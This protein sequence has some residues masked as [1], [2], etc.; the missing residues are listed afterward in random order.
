MSKAE[1]T[2][3]NDRTDVVRAD[4]LHK[5]DVFRCISGKTWQ[6]VR[7]TSS[8]VYVKA[9]G[10]TLGVGDE[11]FCASALVVPVMRKQ[12]TTPLGPEVVKECVRDSADKHSNF[13]TE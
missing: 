11:C 4:S 7:K 5:N 8:L 9:W 12:F 2:N 10:D 3:W 1:S 6:V 13:G